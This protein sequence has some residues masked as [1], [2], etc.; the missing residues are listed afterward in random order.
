MRLQNL[1]KQIIPPIII[2]VVRKKIQTTIEYPT[3][4]A[5]ELACQ[6]IT[7]ENSE[8]IEV[9]VDKNLNYRKRLES[10]PVFDLPSL[11]TLIALGAIQSGSSL[12][13]LDFGGGGGYHYTIA[14][15]A[16]DPSKAINWCVVETST[17]SHCAQRLADGSLRFFPDISSARD[18]F[19][20]FDLVFTSSALQYCP[21]PLSFLR[22]LVDLDAPYLFITRTPFLESDKTI[23][24]TQVSSL[25]SNG[26]GPLPSKYIDRKIKYPLTYVSRRIV[27]EII[28]D[29]YDIR[30]RIDENDGGFSFGSEQISTMGYLCV[31]RS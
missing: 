15:T 25:Q 11:R 8:L 22:E 18:S 31:R 23:I 28:T 3:F 12:N 6:N 30:F 26:P 19:D 1:I 14:K 13:V 20:E 4:E 21:N 9:V 7:Y 10:N 16:L 29:K 24:T 17:M 5:A 2:N 27:E